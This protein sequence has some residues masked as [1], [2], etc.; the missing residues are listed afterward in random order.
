MTTFSDTKDPDS[1]VQHTINWAA[2]LALSS[3]ADTISTSTWTV[4]N[5]LKIGNLASP[6]TT[7]TNTT[8]TATVW[9]NGGQLGRYATATNRI[10]TA[11]GARYDASIVFDIKEK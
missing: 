9:L 6:E 10:T 4:D 5:G 2:E 7:H 8:T 1:I 11:G 3:P